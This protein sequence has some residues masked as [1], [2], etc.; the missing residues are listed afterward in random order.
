MNAVAVQLGTNPGHLTEHWENQP[1]VAS[2]A[3]YGYIVY[4]GK[5]AEVAVAKCGLCFD[6]DPVNLCG[7]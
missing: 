5:A 6:G 1:G 4:T 7:N 2:S 3:S